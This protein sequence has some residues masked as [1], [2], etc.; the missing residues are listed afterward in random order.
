MVNQ[1]IQRKGKP[2]IGRDKPQPVVISP[3]VTSLEGKLQQGFGDFNEGMSAF[4]SLKKEHEALFPLLT[5]RAVAD[6]L[7]NTDRLKTLTDSLYLQGLTLLLQTLD[8]SQ[9]VGATNTTTLELENKELKDDL[10]KCSTPTL[11][12]M[13]QERLDKNTNCLKL[14]KSH[15]DRLDEILMQVGLCKDSIREIRLELPELLSHQSQD[16]LDKIM[17]ELKTRIGFAQRVHEEYTKQGL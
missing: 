3:S 7:V 10:D 2:P 8:I 1:L 14:V 4:L 12:A 6:T 9:Q 5:N 13:I 11:K 16:D 15:R 17:L